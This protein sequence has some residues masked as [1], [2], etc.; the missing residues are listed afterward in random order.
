[1]IAAGDEIA[2][3]FGRGSDQNSPDVYLIDIL[4]GHC[5]DNPSLTFRNFTGE[6][7]GFW[8]GA[9]RLPSGNGVLPTLMFPTLSCHWAA[10]GRKMDSSPT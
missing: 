2:Y 4:I 10:R 7:P 6:E 5:G 3:H 9:N 1:V 8:T